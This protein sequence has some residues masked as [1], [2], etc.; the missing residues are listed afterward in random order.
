MS[1]YS[2]TSHF[3]KLWWNDAENYLKALVDSNEIYYHLNLKL[4]VAYSHTHMDYV[5][6]NLLIT[7]FC[8][9]R[10]KKDLLCNMF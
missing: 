10:K 9:A 8:N 2:Y 5:D 3:Y 7:L 6:L 4:I 1:F